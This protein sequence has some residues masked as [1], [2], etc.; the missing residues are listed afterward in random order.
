MNNFSNS[1]TCFKLLLSKCLGYAIIA[2]SI[3]VKIPQ[4]LKL[5]KNKSGE[6]INLISVTRQ[7]KKI[8]IQALD[9]YRV[10]CMA[11]ICYSGPTSAVPTN[12]QLLAEKRTCAAGHANHLHIYFIGSPTIPSGC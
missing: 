7:L 10:V 12:K 3:L 11:A 1:G 9:S 8:S 5:I 2:G 6:G 4:V